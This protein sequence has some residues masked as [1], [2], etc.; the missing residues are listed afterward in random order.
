VGDVRRN[1]R[2]G[3]GSRRAEPGD[4]D[5]LNFA[6]IHVLLHAGTVYVVRSDEVPGR[7]PVAAV[8]WL[9]L[10][11]RNKMTLRQAEA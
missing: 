1:E 10:A 3:R 9:P 8:Y 2:G 11:K 6:A 7:R 5:L 4:E